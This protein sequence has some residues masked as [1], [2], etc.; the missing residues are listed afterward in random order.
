MFLLKVS[1]LSAPTWTEM[2]LVPQEAG[3][4]QGLSVELC[5]VFIS[6]PSPH[7]GSTPARRLS[8]CSWFCSFRFFYQEKVDFHRKWK[9]SNS[10]QVEASFPSQLCFDIQTQKWHSFTQRIC[11]SIVSRDR[12]PVLFYQNLYRTQLFNFA[13]FIATLVGT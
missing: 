11:R 8:I 2:E 10:F 4:T 1:D 13:P 12:I 3:S 7:K 6:Q 9:W 5:S